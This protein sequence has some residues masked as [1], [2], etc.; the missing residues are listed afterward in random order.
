MK[1]TKKVIIGTKVHLYYIIDMGHGKVFENVPCGSSRW[2]GS[3]SMFVKDDAEVTCKK[4]L[5][6]MAV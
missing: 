6:K 4:C 5:K 2:G 1:T 3:E